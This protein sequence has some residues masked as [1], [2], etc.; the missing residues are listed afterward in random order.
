MLIEPTRKRVRALFTPECPQIEN[1]VCF[2]TERVDTY[3][4]GV[5]RGAAEDP[6][7]EVSGSAPGGSKLLLE[8]GIWSP[9]TR[10]VGTR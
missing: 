9:V 1:L 8:G 5:K 4:D 7:V 6:L 3:V 10:E 2:V